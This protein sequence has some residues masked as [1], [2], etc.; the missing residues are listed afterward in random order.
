MKK[1]VNSYWIQSLLLILILLIVGYVIVQKK[2]ESHYLI[3]IGQT[4]PN[5][6]LSGLN[7]EEIYLSDYRGK[8]VLLNFWASWCNP[9]VNELPLMNEAYKLLGDVEIVAVNMGEKEETVKKFVN[10]YD[11]EFPVLLDLKNSVKRKYHVSGLPVTLLID[12][13]GKIIKVLVGELNSFEKITS[14][15]KLVR[16][17]H[18]F[19]DEHLKGNSRVLVK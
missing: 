12:K 8:G 11:L 7:G 14:L 13:Q 15:M 9:C 2:S 16:G 1:I 4:A 19:N 5:F 10:R 17:I 3:K 6:A 18:N